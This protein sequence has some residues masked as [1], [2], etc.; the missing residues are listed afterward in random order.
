VT[1]SWTSSASGPWVQTAASFKDAGGGGGGG[2][3]SSLL[4]LPGD[5]MAGMDKLGA[6]FQ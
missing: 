4:L 1:M 6:N 3:T 2:A 5:L